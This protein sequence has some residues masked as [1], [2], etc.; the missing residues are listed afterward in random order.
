[1]PKAFIDTNVLISAAYKSTGHS[2]ELIFRA[3]KGDFQ[4]FITN[5]NL[6]SARARLEQIAPHKVNT[7]DQLVV[8]LIPTFI[9]DPNEEEVLRFLDKVR[10]PADAY[11]VVAA[12]KANCGYIITWNVK[13][14]IQEEIGTIKVVTPA[15]FISIINLR[16]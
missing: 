12:T 5:R 3:V 13:D 2:R 1:M 15:E 7:F 16:N 10:K 14:F 6:V 8:D 4:P 9:K 11:I